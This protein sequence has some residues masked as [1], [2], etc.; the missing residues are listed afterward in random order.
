MDQAANEGPQGPDSA[1]PHHS[2]DVANDS[3]L[4]KRCH[5]G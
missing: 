2:P 4:S 1:Q 5:F 3:E